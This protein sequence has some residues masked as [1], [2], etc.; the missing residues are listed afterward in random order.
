MLQAV[1]DV[2]GSCLL[3][4][5]SVFGVDLQGD[6]VL[7]LVTDAVQQGVAE[8]V[9][10][11]GRENGRGGTSWSASETVGRSLQQ[12]DHTSADPN[13]VLLPCGSGSRCGASV[14]PL[15]CCTRD[16]LKGRGETGNRFT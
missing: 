8:F 1:G 14:L 16:T 12:I 6:V 7:D 11:Q 3:G 9:H 15:L 10:G 2:R 4:A 5:G 13:R